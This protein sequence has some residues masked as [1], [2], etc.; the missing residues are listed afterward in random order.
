MKFKNGGI[1]TILLF[2]HRFCLTSNI[3]VVIEILSDSSD[4]EIEDVEVSTHQSN[5]NVAVA[6]SARVKVEETLA[7]F[8]TRHCTMAY[9]NAGYDEEEAIAKAIQNS[10]TKE[11]SSYRKVK[12]CPSNKKVNARH[13]KVNASPCRKKAKTSTSKVDT[14]PILNLKQKSL[15]IV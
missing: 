2:T 9:L 12:T 6:A 4:E 1:Y 14:S 15:F 7:S 8:H 13:S 11:V 5:G 3:F 10:S